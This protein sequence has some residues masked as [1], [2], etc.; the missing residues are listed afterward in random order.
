[1]TILLIE[2]NQLFSELIQSY[3]TEV[4]LKVVETL[5][6][7][8]EWLANNRADMLLVDL[9]LPD[10]KGLDTLVQLSH[11]KTPK[12]VLTSS[13]H[14]LEEAVKM[15]ITDF[16]HKAG[17]EDIVERIRFNI[18]R[19]PKRRARFA[20]EV[21]EQLKACLTLKPDESHRLTVA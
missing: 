10:S 11:I 3:L 21:F 20:P 18:S 17:P 19:L 1:M 5:R 6:E 7:A 12:V 14:L 8:K 9:G 4:D 2:D 13:R 15:G 16:I